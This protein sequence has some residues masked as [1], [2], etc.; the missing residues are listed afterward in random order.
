MIKFTNSDYTNSEPVRIQMFGINI[1]LYSTS[2]T[3]VQALW[4]EYLY[5]RVKETVFLAGKA[6]KG[7]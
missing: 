7:L 1:Y 3:W 2:V 5:R 6:L 4:Y